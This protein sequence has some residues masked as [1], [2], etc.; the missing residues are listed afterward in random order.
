MQ[1]NTQQSSHYSSI[2]EILRQAAELPI[3]LVDKRVRILLL[4]YHYLKGQ[5]NYQQEVG[6]LFSQDQLNLLANQVGAYM[7]LCERLPIPAEVRANIGMSKI[8]P[9]GR[10]LA[11]QLRSRPPTQHPLPPPDPAD[12]SVDWPAVS[13]QM[14]IARRK[15]RAQEMSEKISGGQ[16]TRIEAFVETQKRIRTSLVSIR[17]ASLAQNLSSF[18]LP[19]C[20]RGQPSRRRGIGNSS[21]RPRTA[22][23]DDRFLTEL[24]AHRKEF[25]DFHKKVRDSRRRSAIAIVKAA[26]KDSTAPTAV[27]PEER[28][29]RERLAALKAQDEEAYLRLLA[30]TKNDRLNSLIAQTEE[31][32]RRLGALVLEGKSGSDADQKAA[33]E[34]SVGPGS[35]SHGLIQAKERYF[36]LAHTVGESVTHQPVC[37]GMGRKMRNYQMRGLEWMLSLHNNG[38]NGILADAMGLGK[39]VQT[40]S[41]LAYLYENKGVSG[42]HLIIAPLSTLR[43]NWMGELNRWFP[44][45]AENT[46]IYDGPKATRKELRAR[47]FQDGKPRFNV[48]L[49]SDAYILKDCSVLKKINWEYV[50]VDE[51]HRL[52]NPKSK[53]VQ[54]L[55]KSFVARHRL[56]LTGTP[57]QNDLQE[58]W[59]LLNF[60][61]PRIFNSSDSFSVWFTAPVASA[62]KDSNIDVSEEE[63]LLIIDRLHKV[64]KPFMLRRNKE[65]VEAQLPPR[66]EEVVW[67]ELSGVQKRMY[68][69]LVE[70]AGQA[71]AWHSGGQNLQMNLRKVC[72]HP[73]LFADPSKPIPV[74][75]SIIRTCGKLAVL[76]SVL[77]KLRAT[78]HRVLIFSQM[79]KV[80]DILEIYLNYRGHSYARLDGGTPAETRESLVKQ[81]NAPGSDLFCF[82]L[83]TRAGGLGINLQSADTVVLYDTDYN[84]QADEQAQSRAHRI[85]QTREVVTLRLVTAGTVEE[86]ML[87]IAGSKLEQDQLIIQEGRFNSWEDDEVAKR[88]RLRAILAKAGR[89]GEGVT[90]QEGLNAVLVR[91]EGERAW[92]DR[93]DGR[94]GSLGLGGLMKDL[95]LPPCLFSGLVEKPTTSQKVRIS[96]K[97]QQNPEPSDFKYHS[98]KIQ[99]LTRE[100]MELKAWKDSYQRMDAEW[101]LKLLVRSHSNPTDHSDFMD[102]I[103]VKRHILNAALHTVCQKVIGKLGLTR[104][105]APV[106]YQ[107][108]DLAGNG[109]YQSIHEIERALD[110]ILGVTA[111][112]EFNYVTR[113]IGA[114][115][116]G[117]RRGLAAAGISAS[118][119]STPEEE[120]EDEVDDEEEEVSV[121]QLDRQMGV[122]LDFLD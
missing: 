105:N 6:A 121:D 95:V 72:N 100:E 96:F 74:D 87:E 18:N 58:V 64:L 122:I 76:D 93:V 65:E 98:D 24:L 9:E 106:L 53:L 59:A 80:L 82:I 14:E 104:V 34:A 107:I 13:A 120:G 10:A 99:K 8:T 45:F 112:S 115:N 5:Q 30:E 67:C 15:K 47:Y 4:I 110:N 17:E 77:A 101:S 62:V 41:L 21:R 31:Y 37:F 20:E 12:S 33:L 85:G 88:E 102:S 109:A 92:F 51:A 81:F 69:E 68:K 7:H 117:L 70:N 71:R 3:P 46:V 11:V 42:P 39:T 55:N 97:G 61:M 22:E 44:L 23:G 103:R 16:A 27:S 26:V 83:S 19:P 1:F 89:E 50:I 84:P 119:E 57:L 114:I 90:D 94:R 113:L 54:T 56:A 118:A 78:G 60:L 91:G 48:L 2:C 35:S 86:K 32:M 79:T 49:T 63:K 75:E 36:K 52:K 66:T 43:S 111:Y 116:L 38:L 73:F 25:F 108:A 40:L 28:L 29:Q